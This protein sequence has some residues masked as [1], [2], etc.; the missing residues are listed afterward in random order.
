MSWFTHEFE[1]PVEPKGVGRS[2]NVWYNVVFLPSG[3]AA[4]LPFARHPRFR[5]TVR[6]PMCRSRARSS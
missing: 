4:D 6:S 3:M 2:R 5:S 1:A